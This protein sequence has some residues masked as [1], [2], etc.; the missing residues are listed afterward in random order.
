MKTFMI[1]FIKYFKM[2]KLLGLLADRN[3]NRLRIH[4]IDSYFCKNIIVDI[5]NWKNISFGKGSVVHS[6][7]LLSVIEDRVNKTP[8][9]SQLIVGDNTY[10]GEFNNIRA[11]GGA[12]VIG[13]NV[14]ISEHITIVASNHGI[15]K[16]KLH[17]LQAW[18][19]TK[20]GVNIEDD[21][22]IGA[23]SVILPGVTIGRGAIVGA[24]SIVTKSVPSYA[25]VC[26]N[27][28]KVLKYRT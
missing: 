22:W 16:D 7:T 24:G 10:I 2:Y 28:A 4:N 21:V 15:R 18:D 8:V 27:P 19:T 14:S 25:I 11:S 26:G 1:N 13:S 17:Q 12:V 23:N 9:E 20:T 3:L 6:F 5:R